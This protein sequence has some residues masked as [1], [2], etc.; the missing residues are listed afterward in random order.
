MIRNR[1]ASTI[2]YLQPHNSPEQFANRLLEI[3]LLEYEFRYDMLTCRLR[4]SK[5][6]ANSRQFKKKKAVL[7]S[8]IRV[9]HEHFVMNANNMS[10]LLLLSSFNRMAWTK[11]EEG[12][13]W[14]CVL[15][16]DS[17]SLTCEESERNIYLPTCLLMILMRR[18]VAKMLNN[19][20][21]NQ[22]IEKFWWN[23]CTEKQQKK[24]C[25]WVVHKK[26]ENN[27]KRKRNH[28]K[29]LRTLTFELNY[30]K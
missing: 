2:R 29:A 6:C 17:D 7:I 15:W 19:N 4:A 22:T 26:G 3:V 28:P 13:F 24:K 9:T 8:R 18:H 16:L 1:T 30:G 20:W 27:L 11:F 25:F 10:A 21:N 23:C 5:L 14:L 12:K